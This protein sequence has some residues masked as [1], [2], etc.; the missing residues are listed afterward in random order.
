MITNE[1]MNAEG[2][3]WDYCGFLFAMAGVLSLGLGL[4]AKLDGRPVESYLTA[5]AWFF[6]MGF[7]LNLI[8]QL[9]QIR[10]LL[11]KMADRK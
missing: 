5:G 11:G 8:G 10:A 9:M 6:G 3:F 4:V 2:R 7:A 1:H